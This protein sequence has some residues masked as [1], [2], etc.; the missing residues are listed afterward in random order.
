MDEEEEQGVVGNIFGN[1][2]PPRHTKRTRKASVALAGEKVRAEPG[3]QDEEKNL[4]STVL[5]NVGNRASRRASKLKSS[6]AAGSDAH[7]GTGRGSGKGD[8]R[9]GDG[10]KVEKKEIVQVEEEEDEEEDE[11]ED[12]ENVDEG[13][14]E[15]PVEKIL[16]K[17]SRSMRVKE[18]SKWKTFF[19][20]EYLVKVIEKRRRKK[21]KIPLG[22]YFVCFFLFCFC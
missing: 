19:I 6:S 18:N 2:H 3:L 10:K 20:E 4:K 1:S 17:R 5:F 7:G 11:D 14:K 22:F 16:G 21:K 13:Q 12:D 9:E 8:K 15:F